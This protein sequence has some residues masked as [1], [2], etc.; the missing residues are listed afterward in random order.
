VTRETFKTDYDPTTIHYVRGD[1]L[2][3][4]GRALNNAASNGFS[5]N[6]AT[7]IGATSLGI[8]SG[9]SR[10]TSELHIKNWTS[11]A[12]RR[13]EIVQL[14]TY[15]LDDALY[16]DDIDQMN[17]RLKG[18]LPVGRVHQIAV[19]LEPCG[20]SGGAA[21]V[22][23]DGICPA[24]VNITHKSH[25]R[26]VATEGS[27]VLQSD[28]C[29]HAEIVWKPD[30]TGE[31]WCIVRLGPPYSVQ[32]IAKTQGSGIPAATYDSHGE[33]TPGAADVQVFAW[34]YSSDSAK[35]LRSD[36]NVAASAVVTLE[37]NNYAPTAINV[38]R[39]I[40]IASDDDFK[41]NVIAEFCEDGF[42]EDESTSSVELA[43]STSS[44]GITSQ[45]CSTSLSTT[46]Q[47]IT[48]SSCSTSSSSLGITS[49]SC[50]SSLGITS[51]SSSCSSSLGVTSSSCS[52]SS[53][54]ITSSSCSSSSLGITSS[55]CSSSLGITSSS[56][57]SSLLCSSS[58]GYY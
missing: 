44:Q 57:P 40:L 24:L 56:S 34:D 45:S 5:G 32:L 35:Y 13:G 36:P 17:P 11:T 42:P 39:L 14:G 30:A 2:N 21:R 37:A 12:L 55:S 53:L 23:I 48:S 33:V 49:S 1:L 3:K 51:S 15:G 29:G 26:A 47:G 52:S 9:R 8:P 4:L 18:I 25:R 10:W 27:H 50:S 46:S 20:A 7:I 38:R 43:L 41:W 19:L 16:E 54:G 22:Q 31:Q 58:G 6:G 28:M